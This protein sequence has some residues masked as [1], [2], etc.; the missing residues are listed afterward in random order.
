MHCLPPLSD[1]ETNWST[2]YHTPSWYA[3]CLMEA[4]WHSP[5]E[6]VQQHGNA[7]IGQVANGTQ[8][9][10]HACMLYWYHLEQVPLATA[11]T[12]YTLDMPC[13]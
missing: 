12:I 10:M 3:D 4:C 8:T 5:R 13:Y 1:D 2:Q 7:V 11:Q 9:C 6:L